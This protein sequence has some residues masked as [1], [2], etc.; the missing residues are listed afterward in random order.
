MPAI[1]VD[2]LSKRRVTSQHDLSETCS[3]AKPDRMV[4]LRG[5]AVLAGLIPG[6]ID[7]PQH[8]TCFGQGQ[9]EWMITPNSLVAHVHAGFALAGG[10]HN[11]AIHIDRRLIEEGILLLLP[12][13]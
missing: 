6:S 10:L 4:G 11:R 2:G 3:A 7:E 9:H 13:T 1:Q 8:F 12:N 5:R